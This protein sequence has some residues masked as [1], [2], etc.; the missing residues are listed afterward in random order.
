MPETHLKF[1]SVNG[2]RRI[3]I[4]EDELI[5]QELLRIMLSETYEILF[6]ATGTEALK[7]IESEHQT[8]SLILLDLN[9]PDMKGMDILRQLKADPAAAKVPVI[10]MTSERESEVESIEEGAVDFIPKP[11][12]QAE[13]VRVRIRRTIELSEDRDIIGQT[14]RDQLTGLYNREFFYRYAEQY[15]RYHKDLPTDAIVLDINHFHM[16]NERY[17]KA[18]GDEV[19]RKIGEKVRDVVKDAGGIVCRRSADTF[20][21]YCPHRSDY[22]EILDR[23]SVLLSGSDKKENRVWLRMG[24]Y[25]DVDKGIDIERRFDRAKQA[26]DTV[27]NSF[28]KAIGIYDDSLLE[29]ERQTEELLEDFAAAIREKQFLVYYQPKYDITRSEPVLSSA[30]ALVR[31]KHPKR[32]MVSPGAFIP[33]FEKNGLIQELDNYVWNEA[34]A[35]IRDWKERFGVSVPVSVNISR[36]DMYDPY[37]IEKLDDIV[38]RNGLEHRELLLEI[39]ES[40]YTE[41]SAQIVSTVKQLREKGFRIEMD[42]FGTGY[43]SL[44]M[45]S[46]LPIDALKLDMQFI[47]N[48]FRERKDTRL[49]E[50]IFHLAESLEVPTIAEGVETAEQMLT[51]KSMGCDIVQGYYF[52][53]PLPADEFEPLVAEKEEQEEK[54]NAGR[55][56]TGKNEFTYDALHDPL[57]GLYNHT[58]FEILFHD[59][60]KDHIAVLL[61]DIDGFEKFR[62]E[63]GR[64]RAEEVTKKV[65]SVLRS[66]FRS[67]DDICRL[68][69]DEFVVIMTRVTS[70]MRSQVIDKVEMVNE[71]LQHP[72]DDLPSLSLSVG[73]AFSDRENPEGDIFQDA[74][75]A[76]ARMKEVRQCGCALF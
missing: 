48:A 51:L 16:I 68:R 70:A 40:A 71:I 17:G 4:V 12:P 43:S 66:S 32:G 55:L 50:V 13:V 21:V 24:V 27:K 73:I 2:K 29:Q 69:D 39:T 74:D 20:L 7:I 14:E 62:A 26:A 60:D 37:F 19:L 41:D 63:E 9:L 8:L 49:L 47:R 6:A 23:V 61:A 15:D 5:N 57:T 38:A 35:Q 31:W 18:Y 56:P 28:A 46:D 64:K 54:V 36:I 10:V 1:H 67:V 65:A 53:R 58:A 22:P 34:A 76:L 59:S 44:N 72:E 3:L 33:V 30:E 45:I 42:D 75:T 11:Y 25:A 52:S